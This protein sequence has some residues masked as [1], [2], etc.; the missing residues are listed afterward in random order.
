MVSKWNKRAVVRAG[1]NNCTICITI[2][3]PNTD[4]GMTRQIEKES[5]KTKTK[6]E[7]DYTMD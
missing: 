1:A 4:E 3:W 6:K 7:M 2:L 5:T